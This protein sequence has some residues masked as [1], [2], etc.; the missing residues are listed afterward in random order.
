MTVESTDSLAG[1]DAIEREALARTPFDGAAVLWPLDL[2]GTAELPARA[3]AWV[4]MH[5]DGSGG[6]S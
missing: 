2:S 6:A 1:N 4:L 5:V 3:N